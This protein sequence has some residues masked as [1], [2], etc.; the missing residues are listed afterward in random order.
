[1]LKIKLNRIVPGAYGTNFNVPGMFGQFPKDYPDG[2]AKFFY[3]DWERKEVE[4]LPGVIIPLKPFP[5]I[6]G[7]A[8]KEPGRYSSV[9]PGEFA[10]NMDIRDLTE[11]TTLYVPV[12]VPGALVGMRSIRSMCRL[13]RRTASKSSRMVS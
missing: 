1:M 2:Q 7:V 4:F 6:L 5:G 12:H 3:L 9:P 8:R 10:G 13:R 11:G